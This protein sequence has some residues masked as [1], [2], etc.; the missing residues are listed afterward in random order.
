MPQRRTLLH[1]GPAWTV[2]RVLR[3]AGPVQWSIRYEAV[4]PRWVLPVEGLAEFQAEAGPVLL[5]GLTALGLPQGLPYRMRPLVPASQTHIVVSGP[6][7]CTLGTRLAQVRTLTPRMLWE[8]RRQWR[9]MAQGRSAPS[10]L[11]P[12]AWTPALPGPEVSRPVAR[13]R[14]FMA[15]Q[16]AAADGVRW[17]LQDAAEAAGCSVFH[18][19]HLFRRQLGLSLHSY[20]KRLRMAMALQWLDAGERDL[21]ALAHDLGY[22][23]QSHLGAVFR[24]EVGVTLTQARSTLQAR[25]ESAGF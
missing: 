25:V 2:E 24:R 19:A 17:S 20:R 3:H 12:C 18:L 6:A 21:A 23:S 13:A 15:Q 22:S 5:D 8:L 11:L 16:V 1:T 7:A 9:L 14:L 4:S 10:P